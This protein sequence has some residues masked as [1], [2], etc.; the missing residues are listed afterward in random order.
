MSDL[1]KIP[2]EK[3]CATQ[4]FVLVGSIIEKDNKFLLVKE[5]GKWNLPMGWVELGENLISAAER[6]AREETGLIVKV[7]SFLGIYNVVKR[8]KRKTLH[9]VKLVFISNEKAESEKQSEN[10]EKNK[11]TLAEVKELKEKEMLWHPELVDQLE[12]YKEG[13]RY[14]LEI[15]SHFLL[16]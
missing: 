12:D 1:T 2:K 5:N 7:K 3:R 14:P 11:F 8:K 9:M 13:K 10:L 6:E 4:P 16:K 15:L